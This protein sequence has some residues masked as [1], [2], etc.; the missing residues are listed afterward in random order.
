LLSRPR[1]V[2]AVAPRIIIIIIILGLVATA[3]PTRAIPAFG[4]GNRDIPLEKMEIDKWM[5]DIV[6]CRY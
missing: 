4:P 3:C 1:F 2:R 6:K 5:Q